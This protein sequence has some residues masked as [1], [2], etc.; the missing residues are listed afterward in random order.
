MIT[1]KCF[2]ENGNTVTTG[3]NAT[4]EEAEQYFVGKKFNL[5]TVQDDLQKCVKIALVQGVDSEENSRRKKEEIEEWCSY[6]EKELEADKKWLG[7]NQDY[8]N[9]D[10]L[11]ELWDTFA[12]YEITFMKMKSHVETAKSFSNREEAIYL[13]IATD[14]LLPIFTLMRSW[15]DASFLEAHQDTEKAVKNIINGKNVH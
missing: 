15:K 10:T 2:Y 6:T 3:I 9:P 13:S 8:E 5:G 11:D 7:D 14:I 1:V 12:M 4:F